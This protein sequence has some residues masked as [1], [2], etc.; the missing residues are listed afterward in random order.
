[1]ST[2]PSR[3]ALDFLLNQVAAGYDLS[4]VEADQLRR[5]LIAKHGVQEPPRD[6]AAEVDFLHAEVGA[7]R[8]IVR[9]LAARPQCPHTPC[10]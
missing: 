9:Q 10:A 3:E 6:L 5:S 4:D 8:G 7:L 2:P 1:M